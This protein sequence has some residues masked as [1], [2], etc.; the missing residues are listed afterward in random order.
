MN[1]SMI[2]A[3]ASMGAMQR[4][5]DILADNI[6]N[7]NTDGYKGKKAVFEDILTSVQP[8]PKDFEQPGR[9]SPLGLTLGWGTRVAGQ[10]LDMSQGPLK[11]TGNSTDVAIEGNALFEVRTGMS[12][13]SARA[14][15]RQGAFQLSPLA[16]GDSIL[17]TNT[18]YPVVADDGGTDTFVEVPAGYQLTIGADGAL[19]AKSADGTD[20][21]ELGALKLGQAA[22]PELLQAAADNL[23][24]VPENVNADE[25]VQ[26]IA[27][28]PGAAGGVAI[29]QGY[30]EQSNVDL[31]SEISDLINVQRAYQLNSRAL[32]SADQ[33]MQMATNLRG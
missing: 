16:S 11:E 25:V 20:Q 4:Q 29:R 7:I 8:Q 3:A 15:T 5:L 1:N 12:L 26:A 27:A 28:A 17:L 14:F 9:R 13:D 32:S 30:L 22:R 24:A 23:F 2:S 18:G 33:M 31:T 6:A 19:T 21:V 10:T